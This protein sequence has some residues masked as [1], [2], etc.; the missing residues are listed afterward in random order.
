MADDSCLRL[1]ACD[2]EVAPFVER[3]AEVCSMEIALPDAVEDI[4]SCYIDSSANLASFRENHPE[5]IATGR[6]PYC[7]IFFDPSFANSFMFFNLDKFQTEATKALALNFVDSAFQ[8]QMVSRGNCAPCH[9]ALIEINGR[10]AVI[11]GRG[12]SGKTT[13]AR[14]LPK[15]HRALADDYVM[16][17]VHQGRLLA[18]AMPTWSNLHNGD[19]DYRADC[20]KIT[21]VDA[22]FFLKQSRTDHIE[23]IDGI[24][25]TSH[26]NEILQELLTVRVI[27]DMPGTMKKKLRSRIFDFA[28]Q[29]VDRKPTGI[30]HASLHGEFW[31]PLEIFL[32]AQDRG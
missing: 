27:T 16:L 24:K 1:K 32:Q 21:E 15:P 3:F 14:R 11:G 23:R 5:M 29:V 30:L 20:T 18:Q 17:F 7:Q 19:L 13:C 8:L 31:N 22:F 2:Y 26:L 4:L 9:C 10:G 25:A 6:G 12:D 28:V